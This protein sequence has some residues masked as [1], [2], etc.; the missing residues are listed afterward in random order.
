MQIWHPG[1]Y[2]YW[3]KQQCSVIWFLHF[4]AGV[5]RTGTFIAIDALLDQM[6][7]EGVV[8][9]YK[10]VSHMRSQRCSM[11]QTEVLIGTYFLLDLCF[12]N[13]HGRL[14]TN[15][16]EEWKQI[17]APFPC[18]MQS[19]YKI[20]NFLKDLIFHSVAKQARHRICKYFHIHR[21][22]KRIISN[23]MNYAGLRHRKGI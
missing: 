7:I 8:D 1:S 16:K 17:H 19:T 12:F 5:G 4:S 3:R 11:V 2:F 13:N 22:W 6:K 21:Q 15:C 23:E 10:F 18:H 20:V 9:I 14:Y